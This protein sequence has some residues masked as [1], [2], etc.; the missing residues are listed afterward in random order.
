MNKQTDEARIK[1]GA[2]VGNHGQ[3]DSEKVTA[4]LAV[5]V[6]PMR[7]QLRAVNTEIERL[8]SECGSYYGANLDT[9]YCVEFNTAQ[10]QANRL[11]NAIEKLEGEG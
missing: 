7:E 4:L 2:T 1:A 3:P 8:H 9:R 10:E 6:A 11:R 5:Y